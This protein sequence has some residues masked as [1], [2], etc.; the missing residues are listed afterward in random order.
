VHT[1]NKNEGALNSQNPKAVVGLA[2]AGNKFVEDIKL[3]CHG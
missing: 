3:A 1:Y 2:A